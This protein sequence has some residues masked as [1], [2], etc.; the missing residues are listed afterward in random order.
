MEILR[1]IRCWLGHHHRSR[2]HVRMG[3]DRQWRSKC[4]GCGVRM[5]WVAASDQWMT[6]A[7]HRAIPRD[8]RI[9]A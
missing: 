2:F 8:Q 4:D 9:T 5:Q 6:I 1:K 3:S 7:D